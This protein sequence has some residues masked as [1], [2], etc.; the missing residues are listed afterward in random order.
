MK[1][2]NIIKRI[3]ELSAE[4]EWNH[5]YNFPGGIPTRSNDIDSPGYNTQKWS[6]LKP[7]LEEIGFAGKSILDVGSSD[8]YFSISCAQ[9]GA[10]SVL[11]VELDPIRTERA[12]FAKEVF[13]L[14]NVSFEERDLY[15]FSSDERF[16]MILAL[17]MLHRV[18]DM[19]GL[20]NK[21]S[22]LSD[23][24]VLEYKTYDHRED[25]CYDGQQKTKLN[26]YNALHQIPTN[27]YVKNRLDELGF[28]D[29]AFDIDSQS[30]LKFKRSICIARRI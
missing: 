11:G 9:Q 4:Q 1:R 22:E 6:R 29:V 18:P 21:L 8:G 25:C 7:L 10:G 19:L 30:H 12:N 26:K 28:T 24:L 17:G 14:D 2:E 5:Q 20:L 3:V 15:T 27:A 16:D 23:T 13:Q